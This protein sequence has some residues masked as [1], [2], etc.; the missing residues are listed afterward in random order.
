MVLVGPVLRRTDVGGAYRY[1]SSNGTWTQVLSA[2]SR[3]AKASRQ[4]AYEQIE[5]TLVGELVLSIP[6]W[7][8]NVWRTLEE[9]A[10]VGE[11]GLEPWT[12]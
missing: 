3:G 1:N 2:L 5:P 8:F 7:I 10:V 11:H 4:C 12:R 9:E 6:S